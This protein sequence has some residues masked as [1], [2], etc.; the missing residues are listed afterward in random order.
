ML[1]FRWA[2]LRPCDLLVGLSGVHATAVERD[3]GGGLV[4]TVESAPE[5]RGYRTWGDRARARPVELDLAARPTSK[6]STRTPTATPRPSPPRSGRS[7][8]LATSARSP[9]RRA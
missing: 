5:V 6:R 2:L 4:V 1:T 3:D 9:A 8:A 7:H